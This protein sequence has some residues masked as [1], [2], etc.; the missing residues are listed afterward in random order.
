VHTGSGT[1]VL[2]T[3]R[4][5]HLEEHK[6]EISFPGGR[7]D[8]EDSDTLAAALRE[9]W[10]EV[11][12]LPEDLTILGSMDDFVS[13]TGYRVTPHVVSLAAGD[14]PFQ[15]Q[16]RE[17]AEILLVPLSHLLD[18]SNY[19]VEA[20]QGRRGPI[21]CFRWGSH[22]IWGMTAGITKRFLD[23]AFGFSEGT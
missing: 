14:Y 6:G 16:P 19:R 13:V 9:T 15:P 23:I 2:F 7:V 20:H 1:A 8:P 5:A 18:R 17:V 22:V 3:V 10:E 12:I 21:D 11:G 4:A